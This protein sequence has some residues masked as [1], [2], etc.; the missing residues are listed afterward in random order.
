MHA[1]NAVLHCSYAAPVLVSLALTVSDFI[2]ARA[3]TVFVFVA[4]ERTA[5]LVAV[6]C[7][8]FFGINID[9]GRTDRADTVVLSGVRDVIVRVA[10]VVKVFVFFVRDVLFSERFA[11]SALNMHTTKLKIKSRTFFISL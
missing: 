11:P 9:K 4:P 10:R 2:V 3:D 6:F 8:A 5:V 7:V 1:K